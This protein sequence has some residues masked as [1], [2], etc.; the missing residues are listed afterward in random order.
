M[1]K[2]RRQNSKRRERERRARLRRRR[3]KRERVAGSPV[4]QALT[5]STMALPGLAGSAAADTPVE[6]IT[7]EYSYSRY[8]EDSISSGKVASGST[9]RYEIDVHQ[10][11][12]AA[13]ITERIDLSVD[14]AHETMSGATPWYINPPNIASGETAPRVVMTG[15]SVDDARTDALLKGTYYLDWGSAGVST[16]VSIE[17]DYLAFNG[18]VEAS[19]DYN[20]KNTTLSGGLGFSYDLIDP[21]QDGTPGRPTDEDKHSVSLSGAVSQVLSRK[22][23]IQ[24]GLTYQYAGGFLSDPYKQVYVGGPILPDTRPDMR[25]QLT[26]LTRFRHHLESIGATAHLDYSLY[27]D[28]WGINAHTIEAAWYQALFGVVR[29]IPSVRYYTQSQADFYAPWFTGVPS[30]GN[31]SSD[32]RLS[33]YGALSYRFRAETR[34]QVWKLDWILNVG[35]E[36]YDSSG[37]LAVQS[38]DLENPGLVSF[39]MISAGFTTRF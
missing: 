36:H 12:V 9:D 31:F 38:V 3:T 24:T 5:T 39:D 21:T 7:A 28:D 2:N 33:P 32:Y 22:T 15:A 35:Y 29:L 34:F 1:K 20:E 17:D 4:L 10:F 19:R 16:G 6:Q 23:N 13:P 14:V 26:W 25:H 8:T 11:R 30:D 27:Y 37:D 18:G